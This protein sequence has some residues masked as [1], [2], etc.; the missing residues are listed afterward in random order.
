MSTDIAVVEYPVLEA[1]RKGPARS[2][3]DLDILSFRFAGAG[4]EVIRGSEH[5]P[6]GGRALEPDPALGCPPD[7]PDMIVG[8]VK[9]GAAHFN[10]AM[11]DPVVLEVAL[12]RFGCCSP[13]DAPTPRL[14][15]RGQADASAGHTIRLVA[16]GS[17]PDTDAGR[18]WTTVPM[19]HV[20]LAN[21]PQRTLGGPAPRPDQG[22][23][24]WLVGAARDMASEGRSFHW[25]S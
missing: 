15:S 11:R 8:E 9:E 12:A 13:D 22:R 17:T 10:P 7:R 5:R 14:L 18:H 2:V 20:V 4:H 19:R 3:T 24:P 1:F 6:L 25:T 16:F 21:I 23:D